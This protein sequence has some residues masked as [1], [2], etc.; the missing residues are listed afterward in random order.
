MV[1]PTSEQQSSVEANPLRT[2]RCVW[3][4]YSRS[5]T[6]GGIV[7]RLNRMARGCF[8]WLVKAISKD[9]SQTQVRPYLP[10]RVNW[11]KVRNHNYSQWVGRQELFERERGGD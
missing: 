2:A 1:A 9:R 7:T 4:R 11:L 3:D 6:N 5:A 10:E 8:A